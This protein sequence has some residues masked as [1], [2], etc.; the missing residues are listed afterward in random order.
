MPRTHGN[1]SLTARLFVALLATLACSPAWA[2]VGKS[3]RATAA[4]SITADELGRHVAA[5]ADDTFEGREAGSR[6]GRAAAL[7]LAEKLRA[8]AR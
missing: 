7:Y 8:L 5:L 2:A 6:G 3:S 4:A 1:R